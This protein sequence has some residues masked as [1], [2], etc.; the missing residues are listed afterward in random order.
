MVRVPWRALLPI[1]LLIPASASAQFTGHPA[2]DTSAPS[3]RPG[4]FQLAD[5]PGPGFAAPG[6]KDGRK[7]TIGVSIAEQR[8]Y[9]YRGGEL[10]AVSR[11]S[12]GKRGKA[13]PTGAFTILQKRRWHRSNLY[14]NAPMPFMQRLTWDGIALH[15]GHDPGYPASHGCVRLPYAFAQQ[16]FAMTGIGDA[17]IVSDAPI[18]SPF[19]L[20]I[21]WAGIDVA[22]RYAA[23]SAPVEIAARLDYDWRFFTG[24]RP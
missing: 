15:A 4:Q 11:I 21:D 22:P 12:T 24:A 3:L 1:L 6:F 14:S 2:L 16:L 13:T 8:L 20:E 18:H 17:V 5:I 7:L 10:I 19:R 9:V 23:V